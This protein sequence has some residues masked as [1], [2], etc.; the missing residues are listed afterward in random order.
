MLEIV[1]KVVEGPI[2]EEAALNGGIKLVAFTG[3]VAVL[4]E[5]EVHPSLVNLRPGQSV[6][7]R[8]ELS[9]VV[10]VVPTKVIGEN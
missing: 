8:A 10:Q 9:N 4:Y 3:S 5:H 7:L 6:K 1:G 2:P